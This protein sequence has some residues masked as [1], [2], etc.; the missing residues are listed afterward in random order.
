MKYNIRKI[1]SVLACTAMLGST[2]GF[3]AAA[4][5]P[6]PFVSGGNANVAVVVGS[7]ATLD[8]SA[9]ADVAQNLN[10]VLASQSIGTGGI[11]TVSGGDSAPLFAGT[12]IYLNDTLNIVKGSISKSQLPTVLADQ[13]FSGNVDAK[14]TFTVNIENTPV[15]TYGKIPV[16]TNDPTFGISFNT[17]A[18]TKP[19]YN[20]TV[21]FNKAINFT[22]SDSKGQD[23]TLFGQKFTVSSDT[24]STSLV[25]LKS[26]TRVSLDNTNPTQDVTIDGKKYTLTLVS[27]SDGASATVSVTDE[28]GKSDQKKIDVAKSAKVNGLT[29]AVTTADSNN[30]KYAAS[31]VAGAQKVTLQ[32]GSSVSTG[33][34]DTAVD[35][36]YVKF[37]GGTEATTSIRISVA[38]PDSDSDALLAGQSFVD[39]VFGTFKV[40][41][42]GMSIADTGK[43]RE[44]IAIKTAGDDKMTVTFTPYGSTDAKTINYVVENTSATTSGGGFLQYDSSGHNITV[45]ENKIMYKDDYVI[46]GNEDTAHL[47]KLSTVTNYSAANSTAS[48]GVNDV[49]KFTDVITGTT[50]E[51]DVTSTEGS[52]SI[53]IEGQTYGVTYNGASTDSSSIAVSLNYNSESSGNDRVLFPSIETSKGAKLIF[54]A[55]T[56][57]NLTRESLSGANIKIPNGDGYT[58]VAVAA[59]SNTNYTFGSSGSVNLNSSIANRAASGNATVG[60]LTYAFTSTGNTNV[61]RVYLID[62]KTGTPLLEPAIVLLEEKD[63]NSVYNAVV[64]STS[65]GITSTTPVGVNNVG[66]TWDKPQT[67]GATLATD[68]NKFK[69][70]DRYGAIT[71]KDSSDSK[72]PTATISYPDNQ[73]YA[74]A[75]VSSTDAVVSSGNSTTTIVP[76][77]DSDIATV[78]TKN[79]IVVGGS[80]IN[81]VAAKLLGSDTPICGAD[82]TTKTGVSSGS[83]LIQTFASPYATSTVATLVAGYEAADTTNA[84]NSLKTN[85]PDTTAGKKFTG[86]TA[87]GSLTAA[88]A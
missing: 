80:C 46:V 20:A 85:K 44:D 65:P 17:N 73:V 74:Q 15:V 83:Y 71:L 3:A 62:P 77:K 16:S 70:A 11:A 33:E 51:S 58:S 14:A 19:T 55:P 79:L 64:V 84:V 48:P 50:Y 24:D 49:V 28:S 27:A 9:A 61:T 36:T 10:S 39:P 32:D 41:F 2:L 12:K 82:F 40:D 31:I 43:D 78:S 59:T 76:V 66:E 86:T 13:T 38:A 22:S 25:L 35:G 75:Y 67:F 18:Q 57:I 6:A 52:T 69:E 88:T 26:A 1:S 4:S 5:Y 42:P 21:N 45:L 8:L 68:S 47:L 23:V 37:I 30:F 54:Y 56:E 63:D 72:R 34:D 53:Q 29:L 81:T 60:A 87:T 7:S